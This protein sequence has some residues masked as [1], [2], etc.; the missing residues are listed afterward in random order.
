MMAEVVMT[1]V[2]TVMVVGVIDCDVT[3][4]PLM[5]TLLTMAVR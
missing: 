4:M 2:V 3:D 5:M 1:V